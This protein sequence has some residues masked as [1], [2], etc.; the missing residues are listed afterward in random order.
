MSQEPLVVEK[1]AKSGKE[2]KVSRWLVWW[3]FY[4]VDPYTSSID[5]ASWRGMQPWLMC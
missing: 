2:L 4:D 5:V 1:K 3:M